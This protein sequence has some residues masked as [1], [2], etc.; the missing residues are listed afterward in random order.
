M[1]LGK[2]EISINR[3]IEQSIVAFI[4]VLMTCIAGASA[5]F[6]VTSAIEQKDR[7]HEAV[8]QVEAK[9]TAVIDTT[10]SRMQV[11]SKENKLLRIEME[12]MHIKLLSLHKEDHSS[13]VP[14]LPP[15]NTF[16]EKNY[17][18]AI[19]VKQEQYYQQKK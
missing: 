8:S 15:Q 18:D 19:N 3:V 10:V 11:H 7:I 13:N 5:T 9:L 14:Y 4:V 2:I 6:I 1:K 12:R 16:D 17:K